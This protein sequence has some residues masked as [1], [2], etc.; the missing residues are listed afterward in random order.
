MID[1][2]EEQ[3]QRY[4]R[5]ILLKDVGVE[6]QEKIMNARVLVVGAGGLGAPVAL[7]LAAA[8]IGRIGI[9]DAD[10]PV[11]VTVTEEQI[12]L[13]SLYNTAEPTSKVLRS[14]TVVYSSGSTVNLTAP[15]LEGF[16]FSGWYFGNEC[17]SEKAALSLTVEEKYDGGKISA[18]Y[19]PAPYVEPEKGIDPT[20][21]MIGLVAIMIAIM[22]FAYVL[23]TNRRY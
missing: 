4:S 9:I 18:V 8:G 20:T 16:I 11:D 14:A 13:S 6:G 15:S 10:V 23:L 1:F 2:T 3:I 19:A 22:C 21:L 5:H 7:Y 12:V 17:L